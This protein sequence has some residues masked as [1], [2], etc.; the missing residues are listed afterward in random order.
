MTPRVPVVIG[1]TNGCPQEFQSKLIESG[2][3]PLPRFSSYSSTQSLISMH[4]HSM[5]SM[6]PRPPRSIHF[7][8][9]FSLVS[10]LSGLSGLYASALFHSL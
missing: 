4:M 2:E 8:F 5:R 7:L 1:Q 6:H 3:V 10:P 9:P